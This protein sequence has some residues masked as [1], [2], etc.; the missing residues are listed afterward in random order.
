MPALAEEEAWGLLSQV[1]LCFILLSFSDFSF[2]VLGLSLAF[3]TDSFSLFQGLHLL[4]Q[5][6]VL[7]EEAQQLEVEGLQKVE[8]AVAGLEAEG[9]YGLLRGVLSHSSMSSASPPPKKCNQAPTAT[10]SK[11]PPQESKKVEP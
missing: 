6:S 10:V 11:L 5:A 3:V 2:V 9:L 1:F 8:L 4:W 7:R